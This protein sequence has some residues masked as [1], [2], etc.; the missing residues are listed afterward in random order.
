[1]YLLVIEKKKYITHHCGIFNFIR[2]EISKSLRATTKPV[3]SLSPLHR[4]AVDALLTA[5]DEVSL[6]G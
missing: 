6:A 3:C 5:C 4:A 1:M 2:T